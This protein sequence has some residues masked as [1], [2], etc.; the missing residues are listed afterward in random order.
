LSQHRTLNIWQ[1]FISPFRGKSWKLEASSVLHDTLPE[2]ET[3][4]AVV[5]VKFP[6][7]LYV[8]GFTFT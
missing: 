5:A 7:G 6:T 2:E 4:A 1:N 3:L 8:I